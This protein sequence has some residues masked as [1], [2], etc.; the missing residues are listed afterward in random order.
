MPLPLAEFR[1]WVSALEAEMATG[2]VVGSYSPFDD[3]VARTRVTFDAR[4][5]GTPLGELLRHVVEY[6]SFWDL[7]VACPGSRCAVTGCT[8]DR[9]RRV[10]FDTPLA[11]GAARAMCCTVTTSCVRAARY[12]YCLVWAADVVGAALWGTPARDRDVL[13]VTRLWRKFVWLEEA[14]VG[15]GVHVDQ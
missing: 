8:S 1:A 9:L 7:G 3:L 11:P 6:G 10:R 12:Y 4:V 2:K 14:L 15:L 5:A 13:W